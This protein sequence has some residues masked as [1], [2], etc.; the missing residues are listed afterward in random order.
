M[1][2]NASRGRGLGGAANLGAN[3]ALTA[4]VACP[5]A[6]ADNAAS[7]TEEARSHLA[8][9]QLPEALAKLHLPSG[10][11]GSGHSARMPA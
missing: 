1:G 4:P 2:C 6:A 9:L 11:R 5:Q 10:E 8:G 7:A 3:T